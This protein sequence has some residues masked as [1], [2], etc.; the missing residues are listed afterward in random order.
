MPIPGS[1]L[2]PASTPLEAH[3]SPRWLALASAL[4]IAALCAACGSEDSSD[5]ERDEATASNGDSADESPE[6]EDVP[7]AAAPESGPPKRIFAKRFVVNIRSE[8]RHDA[9]R[10]GYMRAGAVIQAKTAAPAQRD[11]GCPRGWFELSTGGFVCNGRD[12]IAFEGDTLPE[13]RAVQPD[14]E[15]ALP[16]E[17]GRVRAKAPLYRRL[18]NDEE[19]AQHEGY[20]I[21]GSLPPQTVAAAEGGAEPSQAAAAPAPALTTP[22]LTAALPVGAPADSL[23]PPPPTTLGTLMGER[24]AVVYRHLVPGFILSLDRVFR[25][26]TRRYYRT[27]NNGFVPF[28]R[29]GPRNGSDFEG[30][31]L[32]EGALPIAFV[33]TRRVS[34]YERAENGRLRASRAATLDYH[35]HVFIESEE[36]DGN[37][38]YLRTPEGRLYRSSDLVV[39]RPI[40]RPA[41]VPADAQWIDV[42]LTDQTLVAYQ[43]D[44][45]V[46]A[47]LVSTG[48]I[49]RPG[50]PELDHRTPTGVFKIRAKHV[51][52]TMDGDSAVDGPYSIED[53]P[54]VMYFHGAYAIHS[55]FWHD[56]FGHTRSHG[57][58]NM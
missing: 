55:A 43:G 6:G 54:Y 8:P 26:G 24:G 29:I 53:V 33:V 50:D 30:V 57:C 13:G 14:L 21:P 10:L 11:D 20:V 36:Q 16:Y 22:T 31:A 28:G 52:T 15:A 51:T 58:V 41:D 38:S 35:G 9:E 46:Y 5:A 48:R 7:S 56:R 44:R 40:P 25:A 4:C 17:Y 42:N 37:T 3:V 19:A 18:P 27:Q 32:A 2:H 23:E 45:P 12:V 39:I 34:G 47:T 1:D 49:R